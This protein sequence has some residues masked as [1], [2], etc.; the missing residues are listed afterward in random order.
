MEKDYIGKDTNI[1][2]ALKNIEKKDSENY[3]IS[4]RL[5]RYGAIGLLVVGTLGSV[6]YGPRMLNAVADFFSPALEQEHEAE[7]EAI[8]PYLEGMERIREED[9]MS[10][11]FEEA[12]E[13]ANREWY[14]QFRQ[15]NSAEN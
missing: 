2:E 14:K 10:D 15:D 11:A 12:R 13:E 6:E 1:Y 3:S 5:K 7:M 9:E 4:D 8:R